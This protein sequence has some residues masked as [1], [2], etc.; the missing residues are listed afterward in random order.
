MTHAETK[1]APITP[2][3]L[4][5]GDVLLSRGTGDLAKMI[6]A[7]DGGLYSHA[8]LWT[9]ERV[10]HATLAGVLASPL[11]PSHG[12]MVYVDVYRFSKYS[13]LLGT[14]RWPSEPVTKRA[15][16]FVGASYAYADLA[17]LA[18]LIGYARRPGIP[19]MELVVR[20]LGAHLADGLT[21]AFRKQ[22]KDACTADGEPT[23]TK[24]PVSKTCTELVATCFFEAESTPA[25]DYALEVVLPGRE[26]ELGLESMAD[27]KLETQY[28]QVV[29][30]CQ[31]FVQQD[32]AALE[33]AQQ[34]R[35]EQ[36]AQESSLESALTDSRTL[37]AGGRLLPLSTISPRDLQISPTLACVGRLSLSR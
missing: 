18:M 20:H 26:P 31:E 24:R 16:S 15:E 17:M 3:Q 11:A 10:V 2:E 32:F 34:S 8:A 1:V 36:L 23:A 35:A 33:S 5:P 22:L 14:E 28:E 30:A 6:C 13:S 25:H 19:A 37:V 7:V 27:P 4:R 29:V 21:W 9:G 12:P